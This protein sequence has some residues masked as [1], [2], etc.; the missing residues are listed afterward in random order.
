[1]PKA[2]R[3]FILPL[4]EVLHDIVLVARFLPKVGRSFVPPLDEVLHKVGRC[5]VLPLG[6]VPH[7]LAAWF[8]PKVGRSFILP[9]ERE[10]RCPLSVLVPYVVLES[11][12]SIVLLVSMVIVV[13][14]CGS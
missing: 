12:V 3:S 6:E 13:I 11:T 5:C 7:V 9:S 10:L 8:L 1:M 2:R 4:G 14:G